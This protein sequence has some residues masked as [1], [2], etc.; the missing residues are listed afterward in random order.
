MNLNNMLD[1]FLADNHALSTAGLRY[2]LSENEEFE[3]KEVKNLQVFRN[4]FQHEKNSL[5]ILDYQY[6]GENNL[7]YLK[8]LN[9]YYPR[10]KVMVIT[11]DPNPDKM[12][13]VLEEGVSAFLTKECSKDEIHSAITAIQKGEKYFCNKV[14]D[15]LLESRKK[16]EKQSTRI[17]TQREHEILKLIVEGNSTQK[18]CGLPLFKLSYN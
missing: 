17:L 5:F 7:D 4:Y 15:F 2:I 14:Y 13:I 16:E 6:F 3:I 1:I 11:S 8:E 10:L 12:S 9:E 18:N